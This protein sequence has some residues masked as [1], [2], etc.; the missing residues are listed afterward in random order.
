MPSNKIQVSHNSNTDPI[1]KLFD[2]LYQVDQRIKSE[3]KLQENEDL[4]D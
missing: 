1:C 4:H 3:E 2:L